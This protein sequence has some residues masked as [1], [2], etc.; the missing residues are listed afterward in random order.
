MVV[1]GSRLQAVKYKLSFDGYIEKKGYDDIRCL[2][3]FSGEVT[4]D[5]APT[6]TYTE[7]QMNDGIKEGELPEKF[8]SD[9]YQ[10]LLVAN[11]YQT[12]F[13]QP[14]LS[15]MYVDKRL[16]GIQAVQTLSRLNRME[17]R[18]DHLRPRLR[19]R[20]GGHPGVVPGLLRDHDHRRRGGPSAALRSPA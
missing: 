14:L 17:R 19:Q 2:V 13:D 5:K 3:A 11:K 9:A 8:A 6:V 1:T 10:V 4:D 18:Q 7:V 20:A 16:S 12:G 15:A